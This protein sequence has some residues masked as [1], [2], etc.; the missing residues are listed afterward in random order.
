MQEFFAK[1]EGETV[2]VQTLGGD[3]Y[4]GVV[5]GCSGMSVALELKDGTRHIPY[6][7]MDSYGLA[8]AKT[9]SKKKK[10]KA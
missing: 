3:D 4:E 1:H 8:V 6:M 7:A 10:Q 5:V 9:A 2:S